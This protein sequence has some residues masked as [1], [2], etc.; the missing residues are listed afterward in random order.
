MH[1]RGRSQRRLAGQCR[2][3]V[4]RALHREVAAV[5][6]RSLHEQIVRVLPIDQG[7]HPV[8]SLT[9]LEQLRITIA[10]HERIGRKHQ[11]QSERPAPA[12]RAAP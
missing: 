11:V 9:S 8:G 4:H 6:A 10:S 3:Q 12:R 1:E 2:V 7:M 5:S